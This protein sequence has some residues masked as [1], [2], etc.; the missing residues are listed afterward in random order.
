MGFLTW[1]RAAG[2]LAPA[3]MAGMSMAAEAEGDHGL[4]AART[5]YE[6]ESAMLYNFTKFID[7]PDGALRASDGSLVVGVL[8]DDPMAP[9][10]AV[11]LRDKTIHGHPLVVRRLDSTADLKGCAVLLVGASNRKQIARIVEAVGRLPVLTI[12]VQA[13]FSRQGGV[14]AFLRDGNRIRFE[15]NLDAADRA[16]LQ[17]SSK[18][19]RLAVIWRE[20]S[21]QARN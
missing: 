13:Q 8:A 12:G 15:I 16:G 19:L 18:L 2:Y 3:L 9:A 10:L 14:I 20:T 1:R 11:A 6:I 5:E 7:W 17:V 21:P 4:G